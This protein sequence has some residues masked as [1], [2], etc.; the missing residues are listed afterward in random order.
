ME[1][2]LFLTRFARSVTVVHRRSSLRASKSMANRA[3]ENS[4]VDFV[5]NSEVAAIAGTDS[6]T[7]IAAGHRHPC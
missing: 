7:G 1:E 4:K 3:L 5:F 2:A 6:V